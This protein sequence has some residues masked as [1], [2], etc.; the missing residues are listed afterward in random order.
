LAPHSV[1]EVIQAQSLIVSKLL[2]DNGL[3]GVAALHCMKHTGSIKLCITLVEDT[4]SIAAGMVW[5][6]HKCICKLQS[7]LG[8][9]EAPQWHIYY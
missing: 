3:A 5:G 2:D 8:T 7:L 9:Y 6:T 4:T 1:L